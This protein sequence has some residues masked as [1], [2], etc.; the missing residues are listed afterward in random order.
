MLQGAGRVIGDAA[1]RAAPAPRPAPPA[2]RL[3]RHQFGQVARECGNACRLG[4]H[5]PDREPSG[6][7]SRAPSRRSPRRSWRALPHSRDSTIG[8]R[9]S[10]LR[11]TSARPSARK[12]RW[13][14]RAPPAAAPLA[15]TAHTEAVQHA[16]RGIVDVGHHRVLHAAFQQQHATR[17]AARAG[18]R[19][20]P[21][22]GVHLGFEVPPAPPSASPAPSSSPRETAGW[23]VR[24]RSSRRLSQSAPARGTR[25]ATTL[26]PMSSRCPYCTPKGQ[27]DSQVATGEAAVEVRHVFAVTSRPSSTCL[28]R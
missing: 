27:V 6:G 9:A 2:A 17:V 23:W 5:R 14:L 10:M 20:L 26:R 19:L 25:P 18:A 3:G 22:G 8:H 7:R 4:P 12:S 15:V 13:V 24:A 21:S 28:M 11:R 16:R 1:G